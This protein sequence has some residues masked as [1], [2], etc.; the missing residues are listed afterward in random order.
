MT[1]DLV[2]LETIEIMLDVTVYDKVA[3]GLPL[4]QAKRVTQSD[5]SLIS[6]TYRIKSKNWSKQFWSFRR[7]LKGGS[8]KWRTTVLANTVLAA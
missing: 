2:C 1:Q 7:T 8:L 6:S 4:K 5:K 3:S